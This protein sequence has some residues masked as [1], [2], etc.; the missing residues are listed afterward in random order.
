[1][2]TGPCPGCDEFT[3]L[4]P[5]HGPKGGPLCC[6]LC[7]GKWNAEHGRKRRLGRIVIRAMAAFLDAGGNKGDLT[8]LQ[9][10][11]LGINLAELFGN[12]VDPLGYFEGSAQLG[13]EEIELTSELLADAIRLAHP[14]H[15]PPERA[16]L[17]KRTTARLLALQP[18]VFP[19]P[20]PKPSLGEILRR[21]G[22]G[23]ASSTSAAETE[24]AVT[25]SPAYPCADCRSTIPKYYCTACRSEWEKR[26]VEK[27]E[28]ARAKRREWYAKRKARRWKSKACTEC[29]ATFTVSGGPGKGKRADARFCSDR[30]RQRAHRKTV[31]DKTKVVA[32][33]ISRDAPPPVSKGRAP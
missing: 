16:E 7:V 32:P 27:E 31:T 12:P 28:R 14:D 30:C 22:G 18:F 3:V 10:S 25:K 29:G 24:R 33:L 15:H 19:A 4:L 8:K 21:N 13:D 20:K 5:L 11:A 26:W 2:S 23:T 1:M 9:I 17:A 6:P